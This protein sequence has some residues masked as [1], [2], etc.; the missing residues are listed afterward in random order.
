MHTLLDLQIRPIQSE[1]ER[2]KIYE[3]SK[4]DGNRHPL[5]PTHVVTKHGEVVGAFCTWSPTVYWWM[6]TEKVGI[7]ESVSI[8]QAMD[9]LMA[10]DN[11]GGYVL[12]CEPESP[13]FG[14]MSKRLPYF[15]GSDGGDW[16]LFLNKYSKG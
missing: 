5:F 2:L 10:E 3:A 16:R 11:P 4:E 8:F 15:I 12:P 13:Y 1:Q 7:R 9:T 6:H 14:L